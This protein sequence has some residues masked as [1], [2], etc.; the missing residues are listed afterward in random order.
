MIPAEIVLTL[1]EV[2]GL[3]SRKVHAILSTFPEITD[4]R[5]LL[6]CDIGSVEGISKTL[7]HRLRETPVEIGLGILDR[8][9]AIGG[10]YIHCWQPEYPKYFLKLHSRSKHPGRRISIP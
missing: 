10:R 6:A 8:T 3:G 5:D 7:A 9:E 2:P 4:W 1:L